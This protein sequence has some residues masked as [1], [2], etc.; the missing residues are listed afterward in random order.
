M[1]ESDKCVSVNCKKCTFKDSIKNKGVF[2][3]YINEKGKR[4]FRTI[5]MGKLKAFIFTYFYSHNKK[6]NYEE[7]S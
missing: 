3:S 7:K 2:Y 1:R 4:N 5:E 6:L